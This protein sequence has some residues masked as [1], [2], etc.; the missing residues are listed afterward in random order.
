VHALLRLAPLFRPQRGLLIAC[1]L[2]LCGATV[3]TLLGPW[4]VA[5]AIDRGISGGDE[6]LLLR[7]ATAWL[8][9]VLAQMVVTYLSRIG[10]ER[11][12][13]GAMLRLKEQLFDHLV[14]HDQ[15]FHDQHTSG[16]LL[17]RV[18]GDTQALQVLFAEVVLSTPADVAL[19]VGMFAMLLAKSPH[20][21]AIVF[22]V[23][24]PWALAFWLF[25]KYS[26]PLFIAERET[27]ARLTGFLTEHVRAMPTLQRFDREAWVRKR[28]AE[29]ND[30][31]VDREV[32]QGFSTV[33]FFNGVF[34]IRSLGF[35]L[36]LWGGSWL[37]SRELLTVGGVVMGLGYVRQMFNPLMRLSHNLS[38]IERARAAASRIGDILDSPRTIRDPERPV[39]W[40]GIRRAVRI[41]GV[42]FAY[43]E[44]TEILKGVD[45]EIPAGA[46]VA[47]VGAT[48]SGKSTLVNL[49]L[50]FRDPNEGRVTVDGVDLRELA[51]ADLRGHV[52]L[53]LQDVHL[54]EGTVLE[55]LGGDPEKAR[56]ALDR[57]GIGL[58]LDAE[59]APDGKNVSRGERQLLTFARALVNDPD[60]LV[61]DE[62]TSAIDPATEAR[63]QA[64]LEALQA[65]RTTFIVAHRL[66]TVVGCDRIYVMADG[67][68][69]EWGTHAELLARRGPYAALYQ[70][71]HGMAA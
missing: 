42:R 53:V 71:Q 61:L 2:G 25:R 18:Q 57:L 40:P 51:V 38:T 1:V 54:F 3:L 63:V 24:P 43:T 67:Q 41:E 4:I 9:T 64:A 35:A 65:G 29:L 15:A 28:A 45:L 23:A 52:G 17:T 59:I 8:A 10:I 58:P 31:V 46:R 7:F 30:E 47:V 68:V 60:L 13:Q 22:V 34:M 56:K 66:A 55:N 49:L 37:V 12:A 36:V 26:P 44:G 33:V 27:R 5:N 14:G 11:V 19:V 48:G 20:L 69:V 21:A 70:L 16:R 62:A 39:P 50:R 6:A 32:A